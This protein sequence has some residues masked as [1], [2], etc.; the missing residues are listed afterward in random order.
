MP[1]LP[2]LGNVFVFRFGEKKTN[3]GKCMLP[4]ALLVTK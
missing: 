4:H 2:F 1:L 3:F